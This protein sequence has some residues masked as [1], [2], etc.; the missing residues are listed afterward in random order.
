M[1]LNLIWALLVMLFNSNIYAFKFSPMSA[2]IKTKGNESSA[3][4]ALEND[5]D[6][7]IAIQISLAK[8]EMDINGLETNPKIDNALSVYPTQLI[9]PAHEKR[10]A[11]VFWTGKEVP[12]KEIACRLIAEQLPIDLEKSKTKKAAIKVLLRYVAALYIQNEDY[13]SDVNIKSIKFSGKNILIEAQNNG[14]R[15]QVLTNLNLQFTHNGKSIILNPNE[16]KGITGENILSESTRIF[17][18][19]R[20]GKFLEIDPSDSIKIKFD[21]D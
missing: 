4:F 14:K 15:H 9:I 13:S 21:N 2:I 12:T 6:Q 5:T 17:S 19:P 8:R 11:K 20:E 7:P 3:L 16:L 10:S 18:L 1:K